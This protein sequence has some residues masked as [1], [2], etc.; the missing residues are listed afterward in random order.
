MKC[1]N[2]GREAEQ[3]LRPEV[4]NRTVH[5][6]RFQCLEL[7]DNVYLGEYVSRVDT[8]AKDRA[9][10]PELLFLLGPGDAADYFCCYYKLDWWDLFESAALQYL[11]G[12]PFTVLPDRTLGPSGLLSVG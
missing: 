7:C 4:L 5:E 2:G 12:Y 10:I 3:L 8:P 9:L 6:L 1:L 11:E